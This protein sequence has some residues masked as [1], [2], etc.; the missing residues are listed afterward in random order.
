MDFGVLFPFMDCFIVHGGLGTTAE[1]LRTG[2][3]NAPINVLF[4]KVFQAFIIYPY[5]SYACLIWF[6]LISDFKPQFLHMN[7][8][9]S[10]MIWLD[11]PG[12][13]TCVTG[14]LLMDQRF[15]G[16]LASRKLHLIT[17][18]IIFH[19]DIWYM[20]VYNILYICLQKHDNCDKVLV[21]IHLGMCFQHFPQWNIWNQLKPPASTWNRG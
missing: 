2:A 12:K 21:G 16:C 10:R 7:N 1:A 17:M 8:S 14:P 6:H 13:P 20:H 9:R 11:G 3:F 19:N 5:L 15:W 4:L 18:F